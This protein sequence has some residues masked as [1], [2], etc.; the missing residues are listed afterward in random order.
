[1]K[2]AAF[3]ISTPSI[4]IAPEFVNTVPFELW[5]ELWWSSS[6]NYPKKNV[7]LSVGVKPFSWLLPLRSTINPYNRHQGF[8]TPSK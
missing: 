5:L 4:V 3:K 2:K 1:L 8:P 6:F 7:I